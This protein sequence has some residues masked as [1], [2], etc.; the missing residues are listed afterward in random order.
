MNIARTDVL[1]LEPAA[2]IY[3]GHLGIAD[4][5]RGTHKMCELN[6]GLQANVFPSGGGFDIDVG[7][8]HMSGV[9]GNYNISGGFADLSY[10]VA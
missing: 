3:M 6:V 9:N 4:I 5:R 10:A 2:C 8:T 7:L 1:G